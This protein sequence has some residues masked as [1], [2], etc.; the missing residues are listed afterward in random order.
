MSIESDNELEYH[1]LESRD[2]DLLAVPIW[3]G[4]N[5]ETI[6]IRKMIFVYRRKVLQNARNRESDD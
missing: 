1:L 4:F 6:E 3:K 2:L 5:D